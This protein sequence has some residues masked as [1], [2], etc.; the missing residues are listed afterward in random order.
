MERF[1]SY[2]RFHPFKQRDGW[3]YWGRDLGGPTPQV[4]GPFDTEERA[5]KSAEL[6]R[7]QEH[8]RNQSA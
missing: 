1:K 2:R 6:D 3:H 7:I 8:Q 4:C 5:K